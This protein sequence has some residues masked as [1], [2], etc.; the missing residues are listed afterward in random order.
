MRGNKAQRTPKSCALRRISK[1]QR[2]GEN[3]PSCRKADWAQVL[4]G[5]SH[6]GI[7]FA[8]E[9]LPAD[10]PPNAQQFR[11][12]CNSRPAND[13]L[14]ALPGPRIAPPADVVAKLAAVTQKR[15]DEPGTGAASKL[16]DEMH[17]RR[18]D[19]QRLTESQ[20]WVLACCEAMLAGA[21]MPE[22]ALAWERRNQEVPA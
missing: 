5:V 11:A 19:G 16:V 18:A 8:L 14:P 9:R 3:H 12:L 6:D 17:R 22:S 10:W 21:P 4:D 13:G 1:R 2:L 7:R 20:R 15:P